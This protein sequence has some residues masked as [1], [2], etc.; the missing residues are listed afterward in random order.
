[1]AH[2]L[3]IQIKESIQELRN[4]QCKYGELIGK[5]LRVLIEIKKH[6]ATG[7]S[8]RDLANLTGI[9]HNSIVKW[10]NM[11]LQGGI[12][13][14]LIH[15]RKG[16]KPSILNDVQHNQLKEKLMDSNNGIRGYVELLNWVKEELNIE[17][18]YT[19]LVGYSKR[20]FGTKIKVARKSHVKK[21]VKA[22]EAFKKTSV[23]NAKN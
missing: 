23:K 21:D 7:I 5:R 12:N 2:P 19:T 13:S 16:F 15:G 1:M 3:P 14:I 9:N 18:K 10:R 17:L 11:Y 4:L 8:K 6:E 22:E 20:H